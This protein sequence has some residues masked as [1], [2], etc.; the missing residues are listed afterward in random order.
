MNETFAQ[1]SFPHPPA[2]IPAKA[3]IQGRGA[4]W[5]ELLHLHDLAL[6]GELRKG[7]RRRESRV[8][9]QGGAPPLTPS[10]PATP[11]ATPQPF[12]YMAVAPATQSILVE[13]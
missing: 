9:G 1:P 5:R 11:V 12:P 8:A 3:G 2:V 13:V 7:F 4:G 10:S 6:H